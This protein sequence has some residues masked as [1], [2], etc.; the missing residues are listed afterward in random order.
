MYEDLYSDDV[1]PT[2]ESIPGNEQLVHAAGGQKHHA[3]M[4]QHMEVPEAMLFDH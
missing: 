4:L 2:D 1:P 3:S